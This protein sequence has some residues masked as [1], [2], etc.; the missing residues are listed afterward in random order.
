MSANGCAF[1]PFRFRDEWPM[2]ERFSQVRLR[3]LV[4]RILMG[5]VFGFMV[6]RFFFPRSTM[7][8][9]LLISAL[10]VFFA[11]GMEWVHKGR[12]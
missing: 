1:P 10:L 6:T 12:D 9:M 4:L 5:L 3:V 2:K 8:F 7:G 11:Y